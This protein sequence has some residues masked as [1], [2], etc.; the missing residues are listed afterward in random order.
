MISDKDLKNAAIRAVDELADDSTDDCIV[1]THIISS[2]GDT[3][4]VILA[5]GDGAEMLASVMQQLAT[6]RKR[7]VD[8]TLAGIE[9]DLAKGAGESEEKGKRER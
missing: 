2:T 4:L 7:L 3:A 1:A 6:E 8:V 5:R 9:A